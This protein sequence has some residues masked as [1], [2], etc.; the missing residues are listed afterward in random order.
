MVSAAHM[1]GCRMGAIVYEVPTKVAIHQTAQC[2]ELCNALRVCFAFAFVVCCGHVKENVAHRREQMTVCWRRAD[3]P[4]DRRSHL[5]G[6]LRDALADGVQA[7]QVCE[8]IMTNAMVLHCAKHQFC[9]MRRMYGASFCQHPDF[10]TS[11][12]VTFCFHCLETL[13][14]HGDFNKM[15]IRCECLGSPLV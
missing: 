12:A 5:L 6:V 7:S 14:T 15:T 9:S 10:G 1:V 2:F 11:F 13:E 3:N 4:L 8:S